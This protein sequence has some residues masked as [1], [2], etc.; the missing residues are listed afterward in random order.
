V[1]YDWKRHGEPRVAAVNCYGGWLIIAIAVMLWPFCLYLAV[2]HDWT[3]ALVP[4]LP[5]AGAVTHRVAVRKVYGAKDGTEERR[6]EP[7]PEPRVPRDT[8]RPYPRPKG[9]SSKLNRVC[10]VCGTG[11]ET[12][13]LDGRIFGWPA[14]PECK[15]WLEGWKPES[16]EVRELQKVLDAIP[17]GSSWPLSL[18]PQPTVRSAS[19]NSTHYAG[20]GAAAVIGGGSPTSNVALTNGLITVNEAR[21]RLDQ[22]IVG[23]FGIPGPAFS[24]S[25]GALE[26]HTHK[27][28]DPVPYARCACGAMFR[29]TPEYLRTAMKM[30]ST[31]GCR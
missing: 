4:L 20:G 23:S 14:H 12:G 2:T 30:H 31:A 7:L 21:E 11:S 18:P 17:A 27:V 15:E 6:P 9:H 28:G 19:T 1:R 29:G 10:P 16:P 5:T 13:V 25:P 24:M 8:S 3:I 26:E 22:Q